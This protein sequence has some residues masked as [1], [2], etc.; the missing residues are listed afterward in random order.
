MAVPDLVGQVAAEES[1]DLLGPRVLAVE[2]S[3]GG[4]VIGVSADLELLVG[5]EMLFR[6][7]L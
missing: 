6:V 5:S 1:P 7:V 4:E 2:E 3:S